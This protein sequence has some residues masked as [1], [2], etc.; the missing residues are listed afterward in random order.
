MGFENR[1][2]G[3]LVERLGKITRGNLKSFFTRLINSDLRGFYSE[4][5]TSLHLPKGNIK[6][7]EVLYS[8]KQYNAANYLLRV[9]SEST[10][11]VDSYIT[12]EDYT[13]I[14][15]KLEIAQRDVANQL[16][17]QLIGDDQ[18]IILVAA[19]AKNIDDISRLIETLCFTM[20]DASGKSLSRKRAFLLCQSLGFD[21][22]RIPQDLDYQ[23]IEGN[24]VRDDQSYTHYIITGNLR[25]CSANF[26]ESIIN[27]D[28]HIINGIFENSTIKGNATGRNAQYRNCT[29]TGDS[30]GF[31]AEHIF[32]TIEGNAVGFSAQYRHCTITGDAMGFDAEYI[33]CTIMGSPNNIARYINCTFSRMS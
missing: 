5:A 13:N 2:L 10:E 6:G 30:M 17:I 31:G 19:E 18:Q 32:S 4:G 20:Q 7:K 33:N 27:G 28:V 12:I 3:Q 23:I 22:G 9:L 8:D 11:K 25:V 1:S 14:L 21:V 24:A 15:T 26:L 29:I 16:A